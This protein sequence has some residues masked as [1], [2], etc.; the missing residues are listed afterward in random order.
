M[1]IGSPRAD[2]AAHAKSGVLQSATAADCLY[3]TVAELCYHDVA[4]EWSSFEGCGT[5]QICLLPWLHGADDT[6]VEQQDA[7]DGRP[8]GK[9]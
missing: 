9:S 5:P 3:Q 2:S 6:Q 8:Q 4:S 1:W 7:F